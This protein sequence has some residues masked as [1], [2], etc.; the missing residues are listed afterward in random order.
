MSTSFIQS[1]AAMHVDQV[2]NPSVVASDDVTEESVSQVDLRWSS[3]E[4]EVLKTKPNVTL[5]QSVCVFESGLM[6]PTR[7][8]EL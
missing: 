6:F 8:S 3:E 1:L 5:N 2:S 7:A 4:D